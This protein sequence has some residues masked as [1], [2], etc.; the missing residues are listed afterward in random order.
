M[1][2]AQSAAAAEIA[3]MPDTAFPMPGRRRDTIRALCSL[4]AA[5][6]EPG[7]TEI[8]ALPGVGPWTTA[9]VA[10]RGNGN[11]DT[12]P[13]TDLGLIKAWDALGTGTALKSQVATWRPWRSYAANLLW[14]NLQ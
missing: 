4:Y 12:F 5:H 11:P 10:I 3:A 9:M 14:R 1:S 6:D 13:L 2:N 8:E 7:L